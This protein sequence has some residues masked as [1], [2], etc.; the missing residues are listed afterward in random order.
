M[1]ATR[2]VLE[3]L[4]AHLQAALPEVGVELFPDNPAA[5]RF[6]HP[7]AVILIQLQSGEFKAL[8]DIGTVVQE[9][10]L[11]IHFTV[12]A[13]SLHNDFGALAVLDS[14]RLAVVGFEPTDCTPIHLLKEQ[15]VSEEAG[16]WMY[17]LTARTETMQIEAVAEPD[18]PR[19]IQALVRQSGAPKAP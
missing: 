18:L 5:Y 8:E 1:S 17:A 16:T 15:F 3:S 19:F 2:P 14:L 6:I 4:R 11:F 10:Q 13:R 12:M 9:R 7:H